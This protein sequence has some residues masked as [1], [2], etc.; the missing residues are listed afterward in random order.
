MVRTPELGCR[1]RGLREPRAHPSG[2]PRI[3]DLV[4]HRGRAIGVVPA[5]GNDTGQVHPLDRREQRAPMLFDGQHLVEGS[6]ILRQQLGQP[7]LSGFQGLV[8]QIGAVEPQEIGGGK[9]QIP[10]PRSRCW[11][12]GFPRRSSATI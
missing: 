7:L 11:S 4:P 3:S 9:G 6:G 5:L 1:R 2:L 10:F 12:T 8:S